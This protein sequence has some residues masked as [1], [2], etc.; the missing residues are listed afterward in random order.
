MLNWS[1]M[2]QTAVSRKRLE[3]FLGGDDLE[4]DIVR[5]DS[6]FS[7]FI[8]TAYHFNSSLLLGLSY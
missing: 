1:S 5:H 6:S 7:K 2:L 8:L 3:K 4:T